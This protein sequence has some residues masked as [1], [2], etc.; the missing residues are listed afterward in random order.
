MPGVRPSR[1]LTLAALLGMLSSL[2]LVFVPPAEAAGTIRASVSAGIAGETVTF[3]GSL[4]PRKSRPVV[5]QR[6][7]GSK[8]VHV[9]SGKTTSKGKFSFKTKVRSST[10][11]YRVYAKAVKIGRKRYG[12]A[13]TSTKKIINQTQSGTLSIAGSA[14]QDSSILATAN[15]KPARTGRRVVLQ[16]KN[17]SG[18]VQVASGAQAS[19]GSVSLTVPTDAV[20]FFSYRAVTVAANGA[21]AFATGSKSITVS[22]AP[23]VDTTPPPVPGGLGAT[24]G[25]SQVGLSWSA[26]A[27]GDLAGYN[28]YRATASGGPWTKLTASP[29]DATSYS[30]TGLTNG[31]TYYFAITS[32]DNAS[33]ESA[34]SSNASATPTA[35]PDTTPP[36]VPG[37][38][39]ATDGDGH[40]GLSWSAVAAGDLAGYNVYRATA[41]GGPSAKLTASPVVATS[42]S[43]TGLTSG[44]QYW[45]AVTSTDVTGNE[46]A[47]SASATATPNGSAPSVIDHCGE[48]SV[49][50]SWGAGSVHRVTCSVTV[51]TADHCLWSPG[52]SSSSPLGPV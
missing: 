13:S 44:T 47:R 43:A 41:S 2:G 37:G 42:Y 25:D 15:F 11:T 19:N 39:G 1:A 9:A 51:P 38:L 22:A 29:V 52:R 26:V 23:P 5:L 18:W 6:K 3:T 4:P 35:T 8:W 36:P 27:A 21:V 28:V 34:K 45:F 40:V 31:T 46:S 33:N 12:A 16:R 30:A 14:R 20:G 50:E 49:D 24:G 10:T 17:G 32:V 7:S 48:I